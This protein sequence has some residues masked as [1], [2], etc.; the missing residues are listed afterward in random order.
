MTPKEFLDYGNKLMHEPENISA[1]LFFKNCEIHGLR[2][3][4]DKYEIQLFC[5][6]WLFGLSFLLN[7]GLLIGISLGE[8]K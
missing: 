3:A 2:G 5:L 4:L 8:I 6:K 1:L 7:I